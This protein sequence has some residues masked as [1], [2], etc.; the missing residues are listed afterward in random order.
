M[1][2]F[3]S[4]NMA[5]GI[6]LVSLIGS[7]VLGYLCWQR[8]SELSELRGQLQKQVQPTVTGLMQSAQR[9]TQLSRGLKD[10]SL[11]GQK[12]LETYIRKVAAMDRVEVGNVNLAN[13][14]T[15]ITKG[16]VDKKYRI[17]SDDRDRSFPRLALANFL[18]K[19]EEQSRRVKVTDIKLEI[20]EKRLKTHEVPEDKWTFEAEVTSRQRTDG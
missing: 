20:A 18:W 8:S 6:I 5:R 9:H 3:Q 13:T 4:L 11:G 15:P 17:K 2:F 1:K 10:D 16:I 14:D 12:N 19:L 7:L